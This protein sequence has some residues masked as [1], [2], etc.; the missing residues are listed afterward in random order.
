MPHPHDFG[1][2]GILKN[3][4][5]AVAIETERALRYPVV[6]CYDGQDL[7]QGVFCAKR[8]S[9]SKLFLCGLDKMLSSDDLDAIGVDNFRKK[10]DDDSFLFVKEA[11]EFRACDV[12]GILS[13]NVATFYRLFNNIDISSNF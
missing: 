7:N 13:T 10:L 1:T 11:K 8:Q 2:P 5:G 4:H 6:L 9:D 12:A 3:H